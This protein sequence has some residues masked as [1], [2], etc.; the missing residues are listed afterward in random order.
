M[1]DPVTLPIFL[2]RQNSMVKASMIHQKYL[3]FDK[4]NEPFRA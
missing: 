4:K 3:T 1:K 2:L